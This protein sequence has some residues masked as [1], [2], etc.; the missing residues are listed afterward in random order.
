MKLTQ[1]SPSSHL[2]PLFRMFRIRWESLGNISWWSPLI[3]PH[4]SLCPALFIAPFFHSSKNLYIFGLE[5]AHDH[6]IRSYTLCSSLL[7][8]RKAI[9]SVSLV[10]LVP[11]PLCY[12]GSCVGTSFPLCPGEGALPLILF[13]IPHQPPLLLFFSRST[14]GGP[15]KAHWGYILQFIWMLPR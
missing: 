7:F 11:T 4:L 2:E 5:C 3:N 6:E 9:F 8:P 14:K 12:V 1:I 13:H 10:Y 15:V